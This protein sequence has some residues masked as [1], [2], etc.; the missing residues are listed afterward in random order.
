MKTA[1]IVERKS[2]GT[3]ELFASVRAFCS[4]DLKHDENKIYYW[5][6][7]KRESYEDKEIKVSRGNI[8]R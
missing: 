8:M 2:E 1:I 6:S 5:L 7:R 3:I 4:K